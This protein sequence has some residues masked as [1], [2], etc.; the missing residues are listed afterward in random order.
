MVVKIIALFN[1]GQGV[2]L[3]NGAGGGHLG[4]GYNKIPSLVPLNFC[5]IEFI[6][7]LGLEKIEG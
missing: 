6:T 5:A 4:L 3:N 7:H 2:F 1:W